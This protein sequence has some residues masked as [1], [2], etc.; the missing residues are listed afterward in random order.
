M[1]RS[2]IIATAALAVVAVL[3]LAGCSAA[4]GGT[5]APVAS[6]S[7]NPNSRFGGVPGGAFPGASGLVAA[8]SGST[9]QVQGASSQTAVTWTSATTFTVQQKVAASVLK[10]GDCV[11]ARPAS[12]QDATGST[13]VAAATVEITA[14]TANGAC[15]LGRGGVRPGGSQAG[16]GNGY[17]PGTGATPGAQGRFGGFGAVGKVVSLGTGEFTVTSAIASSSTAH[18]T[19]VTY[20][21]STTFTKRAASTSAAV[22]VGV[23]VVAQGKSDD[24]GALTATSMSISQP[25]DG[26]CQN[27]F[28]GRGGSGR[29]PGY[30][31][32]NGSGSSAGSTGTGA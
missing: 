29:G 26:S 23:C 28:T 14:P 13:T 4:N 8:V 32:G 16:A 2:R 24:T 31:G 18:S 11:V 3:G 27:V 30:G 7:G 22:K 10:V 15:T 19:R 6:S 1:K 25:V 20:T 5:P 21:S 17:T 9:A 12:G